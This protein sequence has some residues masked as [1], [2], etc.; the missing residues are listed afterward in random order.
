[1]SVSDVYPA[2]ALRG[3][4]VALLEAAGA[5]PDNAA[6]VAGDARSLRSHAGRLGV[7]VPAALAAAN[8]SSSRS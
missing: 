8:A 4:A 3:F 5:P 1:M 7:A 2:E 6:I